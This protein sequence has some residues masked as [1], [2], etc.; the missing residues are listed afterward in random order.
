MK[1][2]Q[3]VVS[4]RKGSGE[5]KFVVKHVICAG[6]TGRDQE[7]VQEHVRELAKMGVK[8]PATIPA[9]YVVPDSLVTSEKSI[10]VSGKE[11][12]GE[13]ECVLLYAG[14]STYVTVGS[15][16]TDREMERKDILKSKEACPKILAAEVWPYEEVREHWDRIELKSTVTAGGKESIYQEG[17]IGDLMRPEDILARVGG[18]REGLMLYCGTMPVLGG[19]LKFAEK[20]RM[21]MHDPV[22]KRTIS[23]EYNIVLVTG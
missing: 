1:T 13:V 6:F 17:K 21:E 4:S 5:L 8:P 10:K 7:S 3:F 20:F 14:D 11:T 12:S 23:H 2:V 18:K 16:H 19:V 9:A 22:L 15:D